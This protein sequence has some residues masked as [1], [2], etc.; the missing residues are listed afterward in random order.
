MSTNDAKAG[1]PWNSALS[2]IAFQH[3]PGPL[4]P[5]APRNSSTSDFKT[6]AVFH[7]TNIYGEWKSI[8]HRDEVEEF[9][10]WWQGLQNSG[11]PGQTELRF[12][13][14]DGEYRWFQISAAPVHD[15]QGNLVRW[16]GI[17]IDIDDRKRAEQKL[18]QNE[19]DLRTIIDAI[20]QFV[21]VLAPD[22]STLYAN[23]VALENTG[24]RRTCR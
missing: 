24:L 23:R 19:E 2:S 7:R 8:L 14:V 11:K 6:T 18:R 9:E 5:M 20:R 1:L 21:V 10:N 4:V 12:R 17:N 3:L 15:E 22:G 16:Y 13:R